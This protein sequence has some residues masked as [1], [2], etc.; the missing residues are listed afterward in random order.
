MFLLHSTDNLRLVVSRGIRILL[1]GQRKQ[2]ASVLFA[3]GLYLLRRLTFTDLDPG[4]LAPEVHSG[5]GLQN[6]GNV[7]AADAR[8]NL[9]K[10]KLSV[11]GALDEFSMRGPSLQ[12]KRF[13]Q[14]AVDLKQPLL[15]D[16]AMRDR[17]R[18]I[19]AATVRDFHRRAAI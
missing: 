3:R 2:N 17:M 4:P 8:G 16:R 5:S 15:L 13:H 11:G 14:P 12:T 19:S 10:I 18:D 6:V 9:Q 7:S 1:T